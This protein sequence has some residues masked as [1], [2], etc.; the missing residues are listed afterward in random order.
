ME[1]RSKLIFGIY[2]EENSHGFRFIGLRN[3]F[4]DFEMKYNYRLHTKLVPHHSLVK[5]HVRMNNMIEWL[6]SIVADLPQKY[7]YSSGSCNQSGYL[8]KKSK[9]NWCRFIF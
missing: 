6:P 2:D 8:P 5:S 1:Y 4:P 7:Y 9:Y 3:N